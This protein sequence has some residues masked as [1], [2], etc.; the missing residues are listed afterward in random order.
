LREQQ[1]DSGSE[2]ESCDSPSLDALGAAAD[3][4]APVRIQTRLQVRGQE[5][6]DHRRCNLEMY[7]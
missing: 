1:L 2:V 4:Q 6:L 5:P 3:D 7:F